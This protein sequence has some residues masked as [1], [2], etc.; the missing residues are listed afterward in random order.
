MC[1]ARLDAPAS[2]NR[3]RRGADVPADSDVPAHGER[4]DGVFRVE[5]D[6]KVG[7]VGAD[8]EAPSETACR[9]A[10]GGRPGAV[11]ET[12]DDEAR[13]GLSGEHETGLDHLED[14]EAW[15]GLG[16]DG[17]RGGGVGRTS[18]ML[19]DGF[20][21]GVECRLGV[22][23]IGCACAVSGSLERVGRD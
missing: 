16:L 13:A 4:A 18:C 20:G 12:G 22:S 7:D 19:Q 15:G 8:L 11:R 9:D 23:R 3:P 1:Q 14:G 6:D 2:P 17:K 5:N 10:R 21:D